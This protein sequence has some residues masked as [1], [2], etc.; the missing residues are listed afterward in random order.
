MSLLST[1]GSIWLGMFGLIAWIMVPVGI[2]LIVVGLI[3]Y[4][5]PREDDPRT[6]LQRRYAR[7]EISRSEFEELWNALFPQEKPQ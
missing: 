4:F 2:I 3:R 7:G 1:H 5:W 6:I